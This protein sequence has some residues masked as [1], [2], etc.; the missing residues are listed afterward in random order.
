M[1]QL[2]QSTKTGEMTI[3]DLPIPSAQPGRIVVHNRA[4]LV[5]AG[6][7]RTLVDFAEKNLLQKARSRPDL[8]QQVV[9]KVNRDGLLTTIDTVR[10]RLDQP[11][12]LGYSSAGVVMAVGPGVTGYEVGDRVACAGFGYA[13]H[14]EA[15][16]VP[17]NLVVHLP[18]GVSFDDASFTTLGAIALQGIRQAQPQLGDNVAVIG[19][20]LLGQLTLQM[21]KANGCRVFGVDLD[22]QRVELARKMSIDM[23]VGRS[24]ALA[25]GSTFTQNKGFDSVLITADTK[26][27]DPLELAGELSR[28]RGVVVAV[29]AV[30]LQIPRKIYY[31]KEVDIRLSRSYGPGR[32]DPQYE[33]HGIDYPYGYVRWTENRNMQAFLHL[34]SRGQVD[35]KSLITHH[36]PIEEAHQAYDLIQGKTQE[37]FLGVV[38]TYDD[39]IDTSD[40]LKLKTSTAA[41][42]GEFSVGMLGAGAF[43]NSVLLPAIQ[44]ADGLKLHTLCT[45]TG[46]SGVHS[47]ERFGFSHAT[48]NP[49]TIFDN[50]EIDVVVLATPHNQHA[51]QV[52]TALSRGKH[53]FCEKPLCLMAA[54]LAQIE[55]AYKQAANSHLMVGFNRRFAPLAVKM[56]EF[57][58]SVKEP[59]LIH[60]RVN[61]GYIPLDHWT[62][63]PAVGGG[64][65][66]GEVCHF[67][68]FLTFL[69]KS[70]PTSVFAQSLPNNGRYAD[71]NLVLVITYEDGSVGSI[72]YAAN[73]DKS[74]GKERAEVFGG[75][76]TAV[77]EDFRHLTLVSNGK[78]TT[79]KLRLRQDKGHNG[80]WQAFSEALRQGK[81]T[82]ISITDI[83]DTT[84]VTLSALESLKTGGPV[85]LN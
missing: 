71:D 16:S 73:G 47:G 59:L 74:L 68:D 60:Y 82:P 77:L 25:A 28:D 66:V 27:N 15:V 69:T 40:Q 8:V 50:P 61:G 5:S 80:E 32:Y 23:A 18:S 17:E 64:R 55:D 31:N 70:K 9:D 43:A 67:V 75:G 33:E 21:L 58:A 10:T 26:S 45:S 19:L 39:K 24:E 76:Q 44:A 6:T 36:Y 72:T 51:E 12:S 41:V 35:V 7:E 63:D 37:S 52:I 14:A 49:N 13:V 42:Q 79:H 62:Q 81:P 48:T 30:G 4:S 38:L 78:K 1:K 34:V 2:L 29:G 11:M 3:A 57:V 53:V 83:I 65:L 22:P 20:G 54:E 46:V 85:K 56:Q 84:R